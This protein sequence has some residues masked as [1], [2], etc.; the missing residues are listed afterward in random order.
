MTFRLSNQNA[1]KR[2][3]IAD[4]LFRGSTVAAATL[5]ATWQLS[6]SPDVALGECHDTEQHLIA[7]TD[8]YPKAKGKE[9]KPTPEGPS[10]VKFQGP[11]GKTPSVLPEKGPGHFAGLRVSPT[12]RNPPTKGNPPNDKKGNVLK[13]Y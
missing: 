8:D 12:K 7:Q 9:P 10:G 13:G 6:G 4:I 1:S 5:M 11:K 3:Q 2:D